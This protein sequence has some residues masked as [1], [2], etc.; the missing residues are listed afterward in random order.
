MRKYS[1]PPAAPVMTEWLVSRRRVVQG[2]VAS[3]VPALLGGCGG[4]SSGADELVGSIIAKQPVVLRG[5][6]GASPE[7]A[8]EVAVNT[9]V[10]GATTVADRF[11]LGDQCYW[12][13]GSNAF[14]I[15][16]PISAF[17]SADFSLSFWFRSASSAPMQPVLLSGAAGPLMRVEF[18]A[19][20][21]GVAVTHGNYPVEV[22]SASSPGAYTN[23]VWRHL[24]AQVRNRVLEVFVDGVF[25]GSIA[26]S[27]MARTDVRVHIGAERIG[28]TGAIDDLRIHTRSFESAE[29]PH[30]VYAWNQTRA[31]IYPDALAVFYRCD[32]F[33]GTALNDT[34]KI[35]DAVTYNVAPATDRFG[36]LE[37]AYLFDGQTSY[38]QLTAALDPMPE[39][40][41]IAFWAQTYSRDRIVA[42]SSA[43]GANA[44]LTIALND[45][46]AGVTVRVGNANVAVAAAGVAG[47]LADGQWRFYFIQRVGSELQLFVDGELLHSVSCTVA[48]FGLDSAVRIGR[49][50]DADPNGPSHWSGALD[51][52][53]IYVRSFSTDQVVRLGSLSFLPRDGAGALAF[54]GK[55]WLLGGW[56]P[57]RQDATDS[58]IWSSS[59][60][61]EWTLI[62][63]APWE[64]RHDAGYAVFG[65]RM[66]VVG[67][68]PNRGHYQN[69]VWSSA[70]G[71]NWTL[72]TDA[73][74][75]RD[76][77]GHHVLAFADRLWLMGGEQLTS[78][79]GVS[80][81]F[82]DVYSSTDGANW[83]LVTPNAP[84]QGRSLICGRAV[85]RNRMWIMGGGSYA[86]RQ[87][88]NDVWS[89]AD[90]VTWDQVAQQAPWSPRL[91]H[92][93]A[94]YHDKLW[95]IA[96]IDA[97]N[98]SGLNDVWYS[99]DGVTWTQLND[100]PWEP[101]HAT[102][103]M[104]RD[105]QLWIAAG[106]ARSL[107][108]DVW[109]LEYAP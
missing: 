10:V 70:D 86:T 80:I 95:V 105:R 35:P 71:V 99:D 16:D 62:A 30:L 2:L 109:R 47:Q 27:D 81:M 12:Y 26:C 84:W 18:N 79:P 91:F 54:D 58:E 65:G 55:L 63:K 25:L 104:V 73:V 75:W 56:N 100:T 106:G 5:Y 19:R 59:D 8:T 94:V 34:G 7:A 4:D 82:N 49:S 68:D 40:F 43:P 83:Q 88:V 29:I 23:D 31:W 52:V 101:R 108:N 67:G 28:W 92:S 87:Y 41:A 42:F 77:M 96:G 1:V 72:A 13:E 98:V 89:S 51:D 60:G 14:A 69:D 22:V 38:M 37:R 93:L 78:T 61:V 20:Q 57:S 36:N 53:Q 97:E 64:G 66:W 11:E 3:A 74:P 6:D 50:F 15:S 33:E 85:F 107:Y 90:G 21:A 76:R 17:P 103:V 24:H 32:E 46:G 102:S 44:S 9:A 39:D 48:V 45:A